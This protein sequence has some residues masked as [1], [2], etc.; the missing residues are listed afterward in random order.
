[1]P[2]ALAARALPYGKAGPGPLANRPPRLT[3]MP[4][5]VRPLLHGYT[6]KVNPNIGQILRGGYHGVALEKTS[7]EYVAIQ[8]E[9]R[10]LVCPE[11]RGHTTQLPASQELTALLGDMSCLGCPSKRSTLIEAPRWAW[12][13]TSNPRGI[14]APD[15]GSSG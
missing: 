6:H 13:G 5:R 12:S 15:L 8:P 11:L 1:M 2:A 3:H 10:C 9:W 4:M 14:G 7:S